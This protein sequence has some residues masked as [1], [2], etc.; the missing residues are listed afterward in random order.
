M[1]ESIIIHFQSNDKLQI[2]AII[3]DQ[4]IQ[5]SDDEFRFP[6]N[7]YLII[8]TQYEEFDTEYDDKEKIENL[9]GPSPISYNF[10]IRRSKS[11]EACVFLEN[12]IKGHL[13]QYEYILDNMESLFSKDE[14]Q[15][16][17]S[18]LDLYK[19]KKNKA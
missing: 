2:E 7:D 6:E 12:F 15:I 18:F 19:H 1:S 16:S 17:D 10:E 14:I 3:N 9:I 8:A 4:F 5:I 11:N 13:D